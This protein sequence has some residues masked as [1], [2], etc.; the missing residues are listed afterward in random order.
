MKK[1]NSSSEVDD[2]YLN[3]KRQKQY[4]KLQIATWTKDVK[5]LF[6]YKHII[7]EKN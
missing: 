3:V 5:I 6:W 4:W 2:S 7:A 1:R